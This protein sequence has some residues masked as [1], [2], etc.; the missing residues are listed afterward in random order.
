MGMEEW[1]NGGMGKGRMGMKKEKEEVGGG[2][3]NSYN[4]CDPSMIRICYICTPVRH[5]HRLALAK[6][7]VNYAF[8]LELFLDV[9]LPSLMSCSQ[10]L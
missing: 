10:E 1:R 4:C 6:R 3:M 2:K 7:I 8:P 9:S 5:F